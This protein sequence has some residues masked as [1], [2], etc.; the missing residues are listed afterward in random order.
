VDYNLPHIGAYDLGDAQS[1]Y[2]RCLQPVDARARLSNLLL[3]MLQ[4][5]GVEIDRFADSV[6]SMGELC[7]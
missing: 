3:T 1:H 6:E 7:K 4:K 2:Q 5:M